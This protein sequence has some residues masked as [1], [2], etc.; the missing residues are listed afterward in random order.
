[1]VTSKFCK[2]TMA[3]LYQG[4][5]HRTIEQSPDDFTHE[6]RKLVTNSKESNSSV[7]PHV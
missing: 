4:F 5:E 1:M 7:A 2:A 3:N 6:A